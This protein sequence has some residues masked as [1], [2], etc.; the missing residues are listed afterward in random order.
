MD[1]SIIYNDF[2]KMPTRE[3][4]LFQKLANEQDEDCKRGIIQQ[5]HSLRGIYEKDDGTYGVNEASF[6]RYILEAFSMLY[7]NGSIAFYNFCAHKYE[8]IGEPEYMAFFKNILDEIDTSLWNSKLEGKY[9]TRFK[10][11]ISPRLREWS[12]PKD[13]VI[14]HNGCFNIADGVFYPGDH[15]GIHS[16]NNT[17]YDYDKDAEAV[18]FKKFIDDIF[19]GDKDLINVVQEVLGNTLLYGQNPLQVITIFY[20]PG[21]SG[22]GVLSNILMKVHGEQNCSATSVSQL[23]SQFG[24]SQMFDKV[25]NISNENNENLVTDTSIMKTVSGNDLVMVEKK[26]CDAIPVHIYTKLFISTNSITFK[27]S[28]KGFQERLVP[29]PFKYTYVDTPKG[30]NQKKRDNLLEA[31]LSKELSG[32]FNWCYEG[33]VRLRKSGYHLSKSDAVDKER[34]YIVS[35]SNPVQL[36]AKENIKFDSDHRVRKPEVYKRYKE[37]VANNGVNTG[38]YQSA[39][40]FYEKFDAILQEQSVSS[41]TKRIQGYDYYVGITLI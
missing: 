10:R 19:G 21:R 11:E 35:T 12:I 33:L 13:W 39:Q 25:I 36:F 29:I 31:K 20:S 18:E 27:D 24:V 41:E 17:G 30:K 1:N 8:Y 7:I 3:V 5:I 26:Y 22:K 9:K 37:W 15:P 38:I 14:F 2:Y 28:S 32:I 34:E 16:F 40:R 23:S 6:V 4:E